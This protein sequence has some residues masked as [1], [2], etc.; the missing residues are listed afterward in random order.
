MVES[1]RNTE[2]AAPA[3]A[4]T[5]ALL[6]CR[7]YRIAAAE[8]MAELAA[9][10]ES[11]HPAFPRLATAPVSQGD[12]ADSIL[13]ALAADRAITEPQAASWAYP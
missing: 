11:A 13:V 6:V 9:A 4:A 1:V 8:A 10:V 3:Q 2:A 12:R 5:A 7:T